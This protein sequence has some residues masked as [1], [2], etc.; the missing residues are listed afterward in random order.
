MTRPASQLRWA[1]YT[2]E[3]DDMLGA[4]LSVKFT[5]GKIA[6]ML[7]RRASAEQLCAS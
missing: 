5:F 6:D 7:Y 3:N 1:T 4:N 2:V